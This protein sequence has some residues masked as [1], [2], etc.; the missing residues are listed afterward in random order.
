MKTDIEPNELHRRLLNGEALRIIDVRTPREYAACHIP[1]AE[2]HPLQTLNGQIP[3]IEPNEALVVVCQSGHRS[4]LACQQIQ[5]CH[6][7]VFNLVGGTAG[8]R[9]AGLDVEL[10][11]RAKLSLVRQAHLIAGIMLALAFGLSLSVSPNWIYL[12]GLP[13]FGLLLDGLTGICPVT[14][15]LRVMPW[16]ASAR[17]DLTCQSC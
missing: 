10:R 6:T 2:N 8:W 12:A 9:A 11:P 4:S 13:M 16:N 3:G 14:L 7:S 15:L 5:G 1:G 17:D